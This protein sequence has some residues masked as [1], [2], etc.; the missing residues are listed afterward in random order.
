MNTSTM[1]LATPELWV[2]VMACVILMV[3]LFLS[4]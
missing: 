2:L 3:D 1:L 4:E